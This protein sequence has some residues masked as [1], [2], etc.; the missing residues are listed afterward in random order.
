MSSRFIYGLLVWLVVCHCSPC[1]TY[2]VDSAKGDDNNDG[3]TVT[4]PW[5]SLAKVNS[6]KFSPG[7]AIM[8]RRGSLW[9]EQL[10]FP[11]SGSS[12]AQI[13]IDAYG[14]GKLPIISG[15]DLLSGS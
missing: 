9:R 11:S 15:A 4:S 10:N 13:T 2:Y 12:K 8:L 3:T 6:F 14:E 7:D 1:A 5:K